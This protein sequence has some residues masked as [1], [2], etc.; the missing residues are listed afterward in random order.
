MKNIIKS[1]IVM[2]TS[3]SVFSS[4]NAGELSVSGSA[5]ATYN[6]FSGSTSLQPGLGLTNELNFTASGEL[7]NGYTW[8]YSME[9]DP[10]AVAS[11]SG[12]AQNDD[13]QLTLKT[14][15]GTIGAFISEGG[16]DLEDAGSQGVY[17]RAT[18]SGDVSSGTGD[19]YNI[20]GYNSIQYHTPADLLPYGITLKL[21]HAP[22]L[23]TAHASG[24]AKGTAN[25][26]SATSLGDSMT[27]MQIKAAPIENLSIGVS[28]NRFSG[29]ITPGA[30]QDPASGAAFATYAIG[31]VTVGY[32][33][34]RKSP[35]MA[36]AAQATSTTVEDYRQ[37]NYSIA[38]VMGDLSFS[39]E[40]ETDEANYSAD[41]SSV[42]QK[43]SAVQVAYTMGGMS[44]SLHHGSYE[45]VGWDK[46]IDVDQTLLAVQMQF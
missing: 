44:I 40:E 26:I 14:P 13:T 33:E 32:S 22:S 8:S 42:E 16:L 19:N 2:L 24:N 34:G 3:I 20:D 15:Y 27:A 23:N 21:G 43:S 35:L 4:V 31:P 37:Q 38:Y 6:I 7:D 36:D 10:D 29:A 5:K 39:Y 28:A 9:L 46:T 18:D 17:G 12:A 25:T 1:L 41:S 45:N 11:A 30:E